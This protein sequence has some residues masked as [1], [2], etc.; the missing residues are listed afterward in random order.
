MC[1]KGLVDASRGGWWV[2]ESF[3]RYSAMEVNVLPG[4]RICLGGLGVE[5]T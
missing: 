4:G 2:R 3:E 5:F 1:A